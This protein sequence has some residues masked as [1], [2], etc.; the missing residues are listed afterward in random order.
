[1]PKEPSEDPYDLD[2]A[3]R[4][5]SPEAARKRY[6]A[7]ADTYDTGFARDW[8]YVAPREIARLFAERA[9]PEAAP[10]LDVGAGTGL[11]AEHLPGRAIDGVDIAPEML[12]RAAAKGLYDR[13]IEADLTTALPIA[14]ASY[15]GFISC[16][17]FTHGH[18]GPEAFPELLRV[19]RP[20][21]LFVLGTIPPVFD[22]AGIG[23]ALAGLVAGGRIGPLDFAE[24]AIY[25]GADHPHKDDRGLVMMFRKVAA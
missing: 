4:I 19:A 17:T 10:V 20:G 24:I 16:G 15:G 18:V 7:W 25:E 14:D 11:V 6:G 5:D 12:A 9:G 3:Y 8:G 23:S 22:G 2:S 21:A 13:R 1:M